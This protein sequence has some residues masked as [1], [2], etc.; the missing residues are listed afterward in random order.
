MSGLGST[1]SVWWYWDSLESPDAPE[2]EALQGVRMIKFR[3][4]FERYEARELNQMDA[5]ALPGITE[6]TFRRCCVR[7]EDGGEA[8]LL[9]RRLG[10]ASGK[11]VPTEREQQIETLY[12]SRYSDFTARHFHEHLV[13]DHGFTWG[14]TWTKV[15]LQPKGLLSRTK[16]RGAHRRNRPRRPLPG[17]MLHQDGSPACV[18]RRARRDGPDRHDRRCDE[19]DLLGHSAPRGRHRLDV[20]GA[21]GGVRPAWP[22][23]E[24]C[25]DRGSH[26]FHTPEA[27]GPVDRKSPTQVGRALTQPGVEHIAAYSPQARGRSERLF[28]TLQ[29]RLVKELAL[30]GIATV[31]AANNFIRDVY[32]PAHNARFAVKAEQEGSAFVAITGVDPAEILCVQEERQVGNDNTDGVP[33]AAVTDLAQSTG[34][35]L[36]QI[37]RE[38]VAISRGSHAIFHRPRCIGRYDA[39]GTLQTAAL[40]AATGAQK[41]PG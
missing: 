37:H 23:A 35:A 31:A 14:Y 2:T 19:H 22:A 5:A 39:Q 1:R 28:G 6:R 13:R 29:D 40:G 33:Q 32:I 10:Q 26:C 18:D 30:A 11:R 4:V 16:T 41:Q 20:S 7:F 21:G 36:R 34:R 25:T 8:D 38:G 3:S 17:M 15:F 12:R 27:G 9:D 24:L